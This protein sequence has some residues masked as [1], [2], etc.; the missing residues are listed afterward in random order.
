MALQDLKSV[1]LV[2]LQWIALLIDI[3]SHVV[4]LHLISDSKSILLI[5]FSLLINV[6]NNK[7]RWLK[8]KIM[9]NECDKMK[10]LGPKAQVFQIDYS[11]LPLLLKPDVRFYV[12]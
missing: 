1:Q 12:Q 11:V 10:P 7:T 4:S 2:I 9:H 5:L 8:Y 3:Y 6:K